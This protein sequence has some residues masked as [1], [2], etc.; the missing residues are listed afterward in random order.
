MLIVGATFADA[1][2]FI[3][4]DIEPGAEAAMVYNTGPRRDERASAQV[5][6]V[7]WPPHGA[8]G[9]HFT[10]WFRGD[11]FTNENG[12]GPY[13]AVIVT[14]RANAAGDAAWWAGTVARAKPDGWIWIEGAGHLGGDALTRLASVAD[15][16]AAMAE[17]AAP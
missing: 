5:P 11:D 15:A 12:Q 8:D 1:C 17:H 16:Q 9:S 4:Y 6:D 14:A 3:G 10:T 7:L 13:D 2:A